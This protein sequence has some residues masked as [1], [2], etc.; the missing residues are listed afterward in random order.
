MFGT[1]QATKR[2][3]GPGTVLV[4]EAGVDEHITGLG[5]RNRAKPDQKVAQQDQL[6][7][8]GTEQAQKKQNTLV[9]VEEAAELK[10][11]LKEGGQEPGQSAQKHRD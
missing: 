3:N 6:K 10:L 9:L 4:E 5:L 2:S 8:T 11:E 1:T 7:K